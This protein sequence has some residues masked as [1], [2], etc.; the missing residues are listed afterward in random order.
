MMPISM[1]APQDFHATQSNEPSLFIELLIL[2]IETVADAF[3]AIR[4]F[5]H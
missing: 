2:V 4:Q 5:A 3:K 1:Q